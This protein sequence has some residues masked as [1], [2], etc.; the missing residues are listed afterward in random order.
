MTGRLDKV[1]TGV[2]TV[3]HQFCS[4]DPV[5][6]FEVGVE[7]GLDVVDNRLPGVCIVDKVSISRSVDDR[8]S[9]SHSIFLDI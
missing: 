6:L 5:F 8:Q 3:I 1:Y 7:S 9:Q 2:Y 4:V